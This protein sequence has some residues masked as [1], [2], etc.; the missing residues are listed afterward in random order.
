[1]VAGRQLGGGGADTAVD[2]G[3]L[4]DLLGQGREAV[5]LPL[6]RHHSLVPALLMEME[7]EGGCIRREVV[8]KGKVVV[9][10]G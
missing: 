7:G 8:N 5:H 6:P 9:L 1:M 10:I 3:L 4:Q 2:V